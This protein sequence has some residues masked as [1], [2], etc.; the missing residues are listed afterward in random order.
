MSIR[1]RTSPLLPSTTAWTQHRSDI[2]KSVGLAIFLFGNKAGANGVI[3]IPVGSTGFATQALW[4]RVMQDFA[5][6]VPVPGPHNA[7]LQAEYQALG[8]PRLGNEQIVAHVLN[9]ATRLA[10]IQGGS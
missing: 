6:Y 5:R 8:D 2:L 3:P 10:A 1:N 4:R 9:I 7:D